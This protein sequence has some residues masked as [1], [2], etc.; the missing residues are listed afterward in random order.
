MSQASR[1]GTAWRQVVTFLDALGCR[2]ADALDRR[3]PPAP[4]TWPPV[5]GARPGVPFIAMVTY[6]REVRFVEPGDVNDL[7]W[8]SARLR[9]GIPA[10]QLAQ[11]IAVCMVP[12]DYLLD[13]PDL[14]DLGTPA[15]VVIGKLPSGY[16]LRDR[17]KLSRFLDWVGRYSTKFPLFADFSDNYAALATGFGKSFL[18]RYQDH[19][20]AHCTITVPCAALR[21]TLQPHARHPV[22]IIEDPY[23]SPRLGVPRVP[24]GV[25]LRLCWFGNIVS[26]NEQH[27]VDTLL[28]LATRLPRR[29]VTLDFVTSRQYAGFAAT[30]AERIRA[31]NPEFS[32]RFI[33]WSQQA[34]WQS[35][36]DCDLVLLPQDHRSEWGKVKSHNRLVEAIRGGRLAIA[37]PI[38]AYLEMREYAWVGED[39]VAGI[40]WAIANPQAAMAR[41][42]AGQRYIESRFS[43]QAVGRSWRALMD[44]A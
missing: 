35:I 29:P 26:A 17:R 4:R 43:P 23:E 21:E 22:H 12:I 38:D 13:H 16:I 9:M 40:D 25:G 36:D 5:A 6:A 30:L 39:L 8:A 37:S 1:A 14:S 20:L 10:G 3:P 18:A 41:I 19:M 34:T 32:V 11:H 28:D 42:V 2:I 15:A 44:T 27:L 31:V 24:A 33:E 7:P